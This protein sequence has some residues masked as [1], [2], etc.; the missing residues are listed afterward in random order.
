MHNKT[1]EAQRLLNRIDK[2]RTRHLLHVILS[3]LSGGIWIPFWV[4]VTISNAN[5]RQKCEHKL[6]KM[7]AF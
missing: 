6:D 3:L 1:I 7:G 5:E 4:L 2:Y